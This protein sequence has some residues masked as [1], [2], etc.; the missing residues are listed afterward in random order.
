MSQPEKRLTAFGECMIEFSRASDG[1]TWRRNFAGDTF[2]TAWYFRRLS[3]SEWETAY[4]TAVGDDAPSRDMVDFINVA[5]ISTAFVR[6]VSN[7]SPGLYLIE[8]EGAER[9]FSYWR[10]TS[11]A[12]RL[13][14]DPEHLRRTME[15][16]D[17]VYFSGITLAILPEKDR[18]TFVAELARARRNGKTVVFDPNIR[19]R[20]WPGADVIRHALTEAAAASSIVFPTFPDEQALFGDTDRKACAARYR[21]LGVDLVVVKDGALPCLAVNDEGTFEEPAMPVSAPV[22]T[23]GAGDAFNGAFLASFSAGMPLITSLRKAH[24]TASRTICGYGALVE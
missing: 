6:T 1:K 18:E 3:G 21:A 19:A 22:D 12:R 8:L 14:A 9:H 23:T 2:N 24:E 16:S 11:A 10:D 7:A 4:F 17:I 13:A 20:L 15:A 5:G